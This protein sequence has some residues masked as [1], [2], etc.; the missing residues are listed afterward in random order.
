[1]TLSSN[2]LL[3]HIADYLQFISNAQSFWFTLNMS[4]TMAAT[5]PVNSVQTRKTTRLCRLLS[6]RPGVVLS[7]QLVVASPLDILS[8]RHPLVILLH[9]LVVASPLTV[10]SL[11]CPLVVLSRQLIVTLPLAVLSLHHPLVKSLR[12]LVVASPL[13]SSCCAP[14]RPLV[15]WLLRR[16]L[17]VSSSC[18][19]ATRC[20]VSCCASWLSC[21]HLLSS[22]RCITLSSSH[23]AGWLLHCLSLRRPHVLSS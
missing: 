4:M 3:D 22:S 9:Q 20:L 6:R 8:L 14:H 10:L 23:C 12:Q 21:H 2:G 17:V 13:L 11:R 16:P 18:R 1:M 19:A 15:L 7:C 5:S